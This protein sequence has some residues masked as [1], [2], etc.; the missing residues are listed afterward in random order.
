MWRKKMSSK[1]NKP[2]VEI[3]EIKREDLDKIAEVHIDSFPNSALTKLG[4][5]IVERYY[6]WQLIGPHKNVKSVGAFVDN[7][8]AGFSFSGV[9]DGSTS[10][11]LKENRTFLIKEVLLHPWLITNP[12]FF[13]R[14]LY[15][16]QVLRRFSKKKKHSKENKPAKALPYGILSIAVS[17]K[18]QNLGIGKILMDI[19]ETDAVDCGFKQIELTVSPKNVKAIK[20]YEKL[21][22]QKILEGNEWKGYM[23]KN[24]K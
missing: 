5:A 14:L 23:V 19:A 3:K 1:S 18:Y 15:G 2:K 22:W 10:G 20:F 12:L 24:L 7:N 11:F 6:L 16:V 8:C 13:K 21:S 9:F 17:N 4:S